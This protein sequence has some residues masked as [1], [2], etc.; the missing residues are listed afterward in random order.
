MG[1]PDALTF[2]QFDTWYRVYCDSYW[3][4]AR[5]TISRVLADLLDDV[6]DERTRPRITVQEGRTKSSGRL[7]LKVHR[8]KY[9]PE[10][11]ELDDVVNAIDDIVGTR[12]V[13]LTTS[14]V[15]NAVDAIRQLPLYDINGENHLPLYRMDGSERDYAGDVKPSGYRAFHVNLVVNVQHYAQFV[16]VQC[17]LQVRTLLQD[18]WGELTHEDTYKQGA[19]IPQLVF[20]MSRI[21]AD[22]LAVIDGLAD[23]IAGEIAG[24]EDRQDVR[25]SSGVEEA[26]DETPPQTDASSPL[27]DAVSAHVFARWQSLETPVSLAALADDVRREFGQEVG[28]DW[29]G[30]GFRGLVEAAAPGAMVNPAPPGYL[31][32]PSATSNSVVLPS[33]AARKKGA[34]VPAVV[35][36]IRDADRSYPALPKEELSCLFEK[37]SE[38]FARTPA[39]VQVD[40][41]YVNAVTKCAR[42]LA[43]ERGTPVGRN[44]FNYVAL[45]LLYSGSLVGRPVTDDD[46]LEV[47]SHEMRRLFMQQ[48]VVLLG[49]GP[50]EH[51]GTDLSEV[52][53]WIAVDPGYGSLS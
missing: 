18:S 27:F 23:Q 10:V 1:L 7:W 44:S 24:I 32:P 6:L 13:C 2:D 40:T 45:M 33:T 39:P 29:L 17:E 48:T 28:T 3:E 8:E 50:G 25:D 21:M 34:A 52:A 42:D 46:G 31:L 35:S 11:A 53:D 36:S 37:L 19:P 4:P 20:S 30:L 12:L 49:Q 22:M 5:K 47:S 16:P 51:D 26:T 43:V 14:D 15:V 41:R 9:W 38:A